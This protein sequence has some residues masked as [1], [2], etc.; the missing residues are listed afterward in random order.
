MDEGELPVDLEECSPMRMSFDICCYTV[1][2]LETF[3]HLSFEVVIV[4]LVEHWEYLELYI[5]KMEV[6][7]M[8]HGNAVATYRKIDGVV[9]RILDDEEYSMRRFLVL[10]F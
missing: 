2:H 5:E 7:V 9:Q 4:L 3:G 8:V 6:H 10:L 1:H